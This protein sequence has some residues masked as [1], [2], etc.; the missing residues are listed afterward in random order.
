MKHVQESLFEFQDAQFFNSLNEADE[1]EEMSPADKKALKEK[2]QKQGMSVVQ[3]CI[4]NFDSFKKFAGDIWQEYRDFWAT[5][6]E[7][8]ES[9]QQKGLFY[10]LWKS[11]YIAGVVKE[12]N[13]SAALKVFNTSQSDPDEY[14]VF[15]STNPNVVRAFSEFVKGDLEFTMK[16]VIEK[17]KAAIEA[18]KEDDAKREK[19][20]AEA[21][22]QAK[23]D[24][25]LGES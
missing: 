19:E 15:S 24:A 22:K 25:F 17:Q 4:K 23:L 7:A 6:K 11:D 18:K 14:I 5:Q 9:V 10:N 8:D 20:E 13:G 1:K 16:T 2:L 12:P 3:R 21:K